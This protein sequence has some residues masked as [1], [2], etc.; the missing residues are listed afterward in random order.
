MHIT[1]EEEL[2]PPLIKWMGEL[3]LPNMSSRAPAVASPKETAE[4]ISAF[5]NL[6]EAS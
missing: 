3:T 2:F 6:L 5:A 1:N 4:S